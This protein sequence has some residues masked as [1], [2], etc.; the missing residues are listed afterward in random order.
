MTARILRNWLFCVEDQ[1]LTVDDI[2]ELLYNIEDQDKEITARA[3]N[4]QLDDHIKS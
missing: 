3:I 4:I 2:R 1:N